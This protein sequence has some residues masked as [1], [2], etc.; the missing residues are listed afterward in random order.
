MFRKQDD[1]KARA[2]VNDLKEKTIKFTR[3]VAF[4]Y[5]KQVVGTRNIV[6][7]NNIEILLIIGARTRVLVTISNVYTILLQEKSSFLLLTSG[8]YSSLYFIL[9]FP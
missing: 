8:Y 3:D 5:M 2:F 1:E 9:W 6:E 7:L 4:V